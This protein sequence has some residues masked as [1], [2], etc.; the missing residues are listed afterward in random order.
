M[1]SRLLQM[2]DE[3]EAGLIDRKVKVM[4]MINNE[5][6]T[7]PLELNKSKSVKCLGLTLKHLTQDLTATKISH[8]SKRE[9]GKNIHETWSL[10]GI[11]EIGV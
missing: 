5:T 9:V 11:T 7:Y 2:L 8:V 1:D 3:F 4:K 6:E 10:S